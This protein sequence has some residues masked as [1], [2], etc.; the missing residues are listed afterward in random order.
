MITFYQ[1]PLCTNLQRPFKSNC[2]FD[3]LFN[4]KPLRLRSDY[5]LNFTISKTRV[6]YDL[7]CKSRTL[8]VQVLIILKPQVYCSI[9]LLLSKYL[10]LELGFEGRLTMGVPTSYNTVALEPK[11]DRTT[12]PFLKND[13]SDMKPID[14]RQI[15]PT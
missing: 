15:L 10:S 6:A 1:W 8:C 7:L 13:T 4:K 14:M 11:F 5:C 2:T 9:K 3:Y 12:L